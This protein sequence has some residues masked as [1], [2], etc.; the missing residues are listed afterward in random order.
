VSVL[1]AGADGLV[2]GSRGRELRA[3][4]VVLATGGLSLP[5]SGSD[6]G[7]LALAAALGHRIVPTTPALAPLVLAGAFHRP[8][9]GVSHE[10]A[11]SV[12][13]DGRRP[14]R[15]RGPLLWTHFGVSGPLALDASR[16]WHRAT[17]EGGQVTVHLSFVPDL[18]FAGAER[19]LLDT[20][21]ARPSATLRGALAELLPAAV[22]GGLL[23]ALG[24]DSGIRLAHLPREDRRRLAGALAAWEL[25]VTGS[26]GYTYAEATAGGVALDE[27]DRRTMASKRCEGL[28]FA[29]EM[30][31]V[32]GRLGGFNFQWAWSSAFV[33]AR[34]LAQSMQGERDNG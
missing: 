29:G 28:F 17:L 20:A 12:T 26:R 8:L 4:R 7:G 3:A 27:V 21:S 9:A 14:V 16:H 24:I 22:A 34:G 25:P 32:D 30:L 18:D 23:E 33:A 2:V 11:M 5:K 31:D 19:S 6:G 10:A 15:L 1:A 13:V